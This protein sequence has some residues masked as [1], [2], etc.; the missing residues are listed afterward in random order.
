MTTP[1]KGEGVSRADIWGNSIPTRETTKCK[2]SEEDMCRAQS[3]DIK[4]AKV[5]EA[6]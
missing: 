2:G 4:E 1:E 6:V 5:A 3:W